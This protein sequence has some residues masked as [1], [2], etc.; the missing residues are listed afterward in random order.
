MTMY[1][2]QIEIVLEQDIED[3][4][5]LENPRPQKVRDQQLRR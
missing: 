3:E 2:G 5:L 4:T 1:P